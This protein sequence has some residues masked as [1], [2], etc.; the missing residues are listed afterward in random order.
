MNDQM[1]LARIEAVCN[2]LRSEMDDVLERAYEQ[3][4]LEQD[5]ESAAAL[6]RKIRNNLLAASDKECT[7]DKMLPP[8]PEGSTFT[9]WLGW[10][11]ELAEV[12]V[13]AWGVYRQKLRD[14]TL[15]EGFPFNIV[16][17]VPPDVEEVDVE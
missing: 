2:Q 6:A 3:A 12:A 17:P 4:C 15:Q 14:L 16:W 1:R 9:A 10:L 7:L 13:N 11:K 5:E 8:A